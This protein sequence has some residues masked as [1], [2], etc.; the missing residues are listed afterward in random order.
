[1]NIIRTYKTYFASLVLFARKM[2]NDHE[3]AEDIVQD[4]FTKLIESPATFKSEE[5]L[6]GWLYISVANGCRNELRFRK[7][8]SGSLFDDVVCE[9][10]TRKE[11]ASMV[12][13]IVQK[14]PPV[15]KKVLMLS[16]EGVSRTEIS[17]ALNMKPRTVANNLQYAK[18]RLK[19]FVT[20][21]PIS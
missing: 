5:N 20:E 18:K 6:K 4:V 1:M 2:T 13:A 8:F 17:R 12:W 16:M 7:R 11:T 21:S 15:A 9:E 10:V 14:L 19:L 3:G